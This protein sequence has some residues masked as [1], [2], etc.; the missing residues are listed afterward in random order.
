MNYIFLVYKIRN[1]VPIT[2]AVP[3]LRLVDPLVSG[4]GAGAL[5]EVGSSSLSQM[6]P[7]F[8]VPVAVQA[9]TDHFPSAAELPTTQ[10]KPAVVASGVGMPA[11]QQPRMLE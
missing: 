4:V 11:S 1:N 7:N 2:T 3:L 9:K 5:V 6:D 10:S 8:P